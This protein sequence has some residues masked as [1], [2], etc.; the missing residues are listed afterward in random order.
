MIIHEKPNQIAVSTQHTC[1]FHKKNPGKQWAGCTC[2]GS[3]GVR[4]MTDEEIKASVFDTPAGE[5]K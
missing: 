4:D 5:S 2:S 3:F 1:D